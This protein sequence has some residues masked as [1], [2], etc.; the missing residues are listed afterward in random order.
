LV[1]F[2]QKGMRTD[3]YEVRGEP[4]LWMLKGKESV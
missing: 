4:R 1:W 3:I 2:D